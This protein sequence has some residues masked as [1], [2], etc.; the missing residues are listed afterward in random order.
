[1]SKQVVNHVLRDL[2]RLG[3]VRLEADADDAR[4]R[5]VR[6]TA[7]GRRLA[8]AFFAAAVEIERSL[9]ASVPAERRRT[10]PADLAALLAGD[11]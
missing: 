11:A 1:M 7:R 2:E 6:F 5:V 4:A 9:L 3:Y 8:D 10:L